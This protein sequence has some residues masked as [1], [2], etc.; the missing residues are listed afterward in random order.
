M[1]PVNMFSCHRRKYR[2]N[3]P[4]SEKDFKR[5]KKPSKALKT[6]IKVQAL[7]TKRPIDFS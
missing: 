7:H 6:A 4:S 1:Q 5:R 3:G 2:G